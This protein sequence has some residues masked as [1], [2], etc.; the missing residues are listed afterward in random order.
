M[1]SE[2]TMKEE[3]LDSSGVISF[4]NVRSEAG[5]LLKI[6][7]TGT[8]VHKYIVHLPVVNHWQPIK[9]EAISPCFVCMM[10]CEETSTYAPYVYSENEKEELELKLIEFAGQRADNVYDIDI[11]ELRQLVIDGANWM[12]EQ[13]KGEE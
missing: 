12:K 8:K 6:K 13:M 3:C 4:I 10:F 9:K 7:A 2:M 11:E 1:K 5:A